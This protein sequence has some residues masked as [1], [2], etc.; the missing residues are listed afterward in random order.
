MK[1]GV[2]DLEIEAREGTVADVPL[3]LAFILVFGMERA[4][5]RTR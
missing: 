1:L 4:G 2:T 3:L 5:I